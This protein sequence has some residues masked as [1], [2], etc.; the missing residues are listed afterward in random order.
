MKKRSV[1]VLAPDVDH[2]IR[3]VTAADADFL[4]SLG[5]AERIDSVR[6]RLVSGAG[7][8]ARVETNALRASFM[9]HSDFGSVGEAADFIRSMS[10]AQHALRPRISGKRGYKLPREDE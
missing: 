2:V 4:V 1:L 6:I 10:P 8:F 7:D 3:R 5:E 9:L